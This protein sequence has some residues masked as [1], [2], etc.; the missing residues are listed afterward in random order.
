MDQEAILE[1]IDMYASE[2]IGGGQPMGD[3][4]RA[5]LIPGL[6]EQPA[7]RYFLVFD[8]NA[9]VGV[10]ICFLGFSTF[11]ARPLLNI[12]DLAVHRDCRLQGIG[13]RLLA[14]I[15]EE[16]RRLGCCKLTLEV[17]RDNTIAKGL[18]ER[19]GFDSG[20]DG[21]DMAFLSKVLAV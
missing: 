3:E 12:H 11:R 8:D 1:L 2:P 19:L 16:A 9:A 15:E 5:R 7:G 21:A 18:Y 13:R 17:R 4:V 10:A 14:A 20:P 6:R